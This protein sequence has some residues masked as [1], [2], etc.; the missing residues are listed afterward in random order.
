[1][2]SVSL[3]FAKF[4]KSSVF[5]DADLVFLSFGVSRDGGNYVNYLS[6]FLTYYDISFKN[7]SKKQQTVLS[8]HIWNKGLEPNP[9][10][11][12][13]IIAHAHTY[14][15]GGRYCDLCTTEKWLIAKNLKDPACLNKRNDYTNK[16]AHIAKHKLNKIKPG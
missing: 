15:K 6:H 2:M 16:C 1:M 3:L 9:D 7:S 4:I 12:W 13:E 10:I 8:Q 14:R 11:K 5:H